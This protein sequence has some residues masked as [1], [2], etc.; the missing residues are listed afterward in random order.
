MG[1]LAPS[2]LKQKTVKMDLK[3]HTVLITGGSRGIGFAMAKAFVAQGNKVIITGRSDDNLQKAKQLLPDIDTLLCDLSSP[4]AIVELVAEVRI[5]YPEL[6]MLVNNAGIQ[7]NYS[8]K[9]NRGLTERID[10][11][12]QTNLNAPIQLCARLLPLLSKNPNAAVINVSSGLGLVPKASAPVYCA[13]KAGIH[14]FS[15]ALRYQMTDVKVF[16]VI[17]PLVATDMTKGRGKGKISPDQLVQEFM[18]GL[19]K[20]RMEM[21]I[22]KTKLLRFVQRISPIV[23]DAILKNA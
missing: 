4:L 1:I 8:F 18:V 14:V 20:D 2:I 11:E 22:G 3:G 16:E 5:K 23:A 19:S 13:T 15:K 10:K 6:N 17:P 7:Y 9:E 21:N 12:I